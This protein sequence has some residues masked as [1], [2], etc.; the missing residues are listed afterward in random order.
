MIG[1]KNIGIVDFGDKDYWK[2]VSSLESVV[3]TLASQSDGPNIPIS[4][5]ITRSPYVTPSTRGTDSIDFFLNYTP[6]IVAAQMVPYLDVE[7]ELSRGFSE[8]DDTYLSTPSSL[9]FLLGSKKLSDLSAADKAIEKCGL[10]IVRP[11]EGKGRAKKQDEKPEAYSF[12]GMEMFLMP[13]TLTNMDSLNPDGVI[14]L[15]RVKPFLP[16]AS[17]EEIGRA[18]V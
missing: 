18:H 2:D 10:Q 11:K 14:R 7:F 4:A 1:T 9:R 3:P 6:P 16:F 13:Q 8:I 17:I 12:T 15:A 5:F